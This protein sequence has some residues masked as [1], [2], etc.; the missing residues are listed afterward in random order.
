M[1]AKIK[2]Q[3]G[4]ILVLALIIMSVLLATAIGFAVVVI[5]DIKQAKAVDNSVLAYYGADAGMERSLYVLRRDEQIEYLGDRSTNNTL[6]NFFHNINGGPAEIALANGA[7]WSIIGSSDSE[8][9]FVR[10]RLYNGQSLKIY[11]L[12]RESGNPAERVDVYWRQGAA[13]TAKMQVIFTQ[14]KP[15]FTTD[16]TLVYYTD[17]N[18]VEI[19]DS[20]TTGS[21]FSYEFG[22]KNIEGNS[23]KSD[24]LM[25]IRALGSGNDYIDQITIRAFDVNSQLINNGITNLTLKSVGNFG[26]F[27]Q[28]IIAHLPPRDP[29]SGLLGFVL[30]SEEDITKSY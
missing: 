2:N 19:S 17:K 7:N 28:S 12:G 14:L 8:A 5:G 20:V 22:D 11:F 10:Q 6:V 3:K 24:Y 18:E 1:T 21:D 30:F 25:E 16:G 26:G 9:T 27:E 4:V 13:S 29:V 15:Q 23:F